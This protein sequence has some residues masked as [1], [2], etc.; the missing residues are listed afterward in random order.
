MNKPLWI[1]TNL[2]PLDLKPKSENVK[3]IK[4]NEKKV[5]EWY[6]KG[7][8]Q[9]IWI[10]DQSTKCRLDLRNNHIEIT[11]ANK[12]IE[13]AHKKSKLHEMNEYNS[14]IQEKGASIQVGAL[15]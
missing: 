3:I 13:V 1:C 11:K 9:Q 2:I 8:R 10:S 12:S 7:N 15:L 6:N 14:Q 4:N 5:I